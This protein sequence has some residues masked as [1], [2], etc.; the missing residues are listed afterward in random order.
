MT[1]PSMNH[2]DRAIQLHQKA[3]VVDC[4]C[5]TLL[6][7][8]PSRYIDRFIIEHM[9]QRMPQ[10]V[11]GFLRAMKPIRLGE[12]NTEGCVD[13]PRLV[14]GGVNCQVFAIY[15]ES[16]FLPEKALRR[17]MELLDAFYQ[18]FNE[19]RETLSPAFTFPD[20]LK[21]NREGKVAAV[22]SLEG[23]EALEDTE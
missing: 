8:A 2:E 22:L 20:I 1:Q 14:E 10:G 19:N 13:L 16:A 9:L 5:D 3:V 4:H 15:V 7:L 17:S 21:A 18:H 12:K 23:G 11:P 6:R